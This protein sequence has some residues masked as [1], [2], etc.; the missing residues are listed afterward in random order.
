[1]AYQEG[2]INETCERINE[3]FVVKCVETIKEPLEVVVEEFN[4]PVVVTIDQLSKPIDIA[5]TSIPHTPFLSF[6]A[7][8]FISIGVS[9]VA[10]IAAFFSS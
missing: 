5:V 8:D 6:D 3:T 1:M 7:S 2:I 4:N 10:A 9:L